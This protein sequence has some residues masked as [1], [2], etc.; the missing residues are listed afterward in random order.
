MRAA[1][2]TTSRPCTNSVKLR[3]ARI[4][5]AEFALKEA[6]IAL[7]AAGV[8]RQDVQASEA[9]LKRAALEYGKARE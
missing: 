9:A 3:K 5:V 1:V 2:S 8:A 4:E 7:L 6:A